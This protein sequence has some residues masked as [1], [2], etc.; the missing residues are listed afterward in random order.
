MPEQPEPRARKK[1]LFDPGAIQLLAER[2]RQAGGKRILM[3]DDSA[4]IIAHA[5][6]T[7]THLIRSSA[8]REMPFSVEWWTLDGSSIEQVLVRATHGL[9][10]RAA[11]EKACAEMPNAR[12]ALR[13][14]ARPMAERVPNVAAPHV[15]AEPPQR[16]GIDG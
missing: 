1:H 12:I 7:Y 9:I 3:T 16:G 10:A 13:N 14:G 15:V 2:F 5:L 11:Y 6:R 8:E 4:Q